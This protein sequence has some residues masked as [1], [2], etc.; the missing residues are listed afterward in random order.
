M[1][2]KIYFIDAYSWFKFNNLE[3]AEVMTLTIYRSVAKWLKLKVKKRMGLK[4][5]VKKDVL[6]NFEKITGKKFCWS[7]LFDK[8]IEQVW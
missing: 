3:L 7:L 4:K 2:R 1:T 8:I 6:K 5:D